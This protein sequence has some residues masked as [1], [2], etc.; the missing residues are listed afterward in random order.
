MFLGWTAASSV[1]AILGLA[2]M[3]YGFYSILRI[4]F[5]I[6][7]CVGMAAAFKKN[8]SG[9]I[10]AFGG[11]TLLYNP[12]TP[13]RLGSKVTWTALNVLTLIVFWWANSAFRKLRT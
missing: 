2:R 12:I 4:V 3:P 11:L 6:T 5:C 1:F 13:I 7:A 9:W 10:A 8:S